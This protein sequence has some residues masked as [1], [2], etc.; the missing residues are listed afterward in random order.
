MESDN[1]RIKKIGPLTQ[2]IK[3]DI[4]LDDRCIEEYGEE[5]LNIVKKMSAN[6]YEPDSQLYADYQEF[7]DLLNGIDNSSED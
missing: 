7:L 1:I 3:K 6:P 2:P 4:E 5:Y